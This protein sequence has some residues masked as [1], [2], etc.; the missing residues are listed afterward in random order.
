MPEWDQMETV[1]FSTRQH[2][3]VVEHAFSDDREGEE[4]G[5]WKRVSGESNGCGVPRTEKL[6]VHRRAWR[7]DL[8]GAGATF[9]DAPD[10]LG[11]VH[12]SANERKMEKRKRSTSS[13]CQVLTGPTWVY[14]GV[15]N[16]SSPL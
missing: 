10:L 13:A 9:M 2:L 14:W 4:Q 12:R 3:R 15:E 7:A 1:L 8:P 16:I 11:A 6:F 5:I